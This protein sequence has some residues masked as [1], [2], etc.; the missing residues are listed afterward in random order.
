[1]HMKKYQGVQLSVTAKAC[2]NGKRN[3]QKYNSSEINEGTSI[4]R[5]SG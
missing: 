5:N 3:V 1:M 4:R 2:D